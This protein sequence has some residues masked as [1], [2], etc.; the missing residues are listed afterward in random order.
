[1]KKNIGSKNHNWTG[2]DASYGAIH[3]WIHRH[4]RKPKKCQMCNKRARLDAANISGKYERDIH[5]FLWLCRKCH[6]KS[7]GR[8]KSLIIRNKQYGK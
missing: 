8:L 5:D 3:L 1:M 4:K 7:D 6:M 2:D